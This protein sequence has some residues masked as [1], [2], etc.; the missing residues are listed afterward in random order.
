MEEACSVAEIREKLRTF[1]PFEAGKELRENLRHLAI[2][3]EPKNDYIDYLRFMN[4]HPCNF[5]VN[6]PQSMNHPYYWTMFSVVSQHVMGDCVEEC[7][8]KAIE[9]SEQ[10][11]PKSTF[12]LVN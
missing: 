7:L 1:V 12:S 8:D 9:I 11:V 10:K 4:Q 5:D 2:R 6:H 3:Y